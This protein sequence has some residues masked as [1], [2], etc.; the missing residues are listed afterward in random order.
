MFLNAPQIQYDDIVTGEKFTCACEAIYYHYELCNMKNTDSA[1]LFYTDTY[2]FEDL[3][4]LLPQTPVTL[5]SHNADR[6]FTDE[7]AAAMPSNV[8]KCFSVNVA[9]AHEKVIPI[10][11]GLENERWYS[12]QKRKQKILDQR[13][14][15][16]RPIKLLYSNFSIET[17]HAARQVAFDKFKDVSWCTTRPWNRERA[18]R[19]EN[20]DNYVW[21][22]LDHFYVLSPEGNGIDCHR[23]WE[24]MYLNRVP[25]LLRN[26]NTKQ[27]ED[28]PVL[29]VDSWDEITEQFLL[30]RCNYFAHTEFNYKKLKFEYWKDLIWKR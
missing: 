14:K 18:N 2:K 23:T 6:A 28:M 10:P 17:N 27:Y 15:N 30:D 8:E 24:A 29:L 1:R 12:D 16:V 7:M 26:H 4:P 13:N 25:V 21:D 20:F 3:L 11:I 19:G 5:V 22:I 9:T